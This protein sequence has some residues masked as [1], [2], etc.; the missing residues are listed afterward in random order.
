MNT[1]AQGVFSFC[2]QA[3]SQTAETPADNCVIRP[4][5]SPAER[6]ILFAEFDRRADAEEQWRLES[7]RK[8]EARAVYEQAKRLK[9]NGP[10]RGHVAD[11]EEYGDLEHEARMDWDAHHEARIGGVLEEKRASD[12]HEHTLALAGYTLGRDEF[13]ASVRRRWQ[14]YQDTLDLANAL[15]S[16]G[17]EA[18]YTGK[19]GRP[20]PS[21]VCPIS[22]RAIPLPSIRRLNFFPETAASR[23]S[24]MLKEVEAYLERHEWARMATFTAGGRVPTCE[25]RATHSALTR[26][27][28]RLADEKWFKRRAELVFRA[29]EYGTPRLCG[30][31][32]NWTWHVHAHAIF[33]PFR[34]YT[35]KAWKVFLQRVGRYMGAHWDAGRPVENARELVKYPVKPADLR[36]LLA[37]GGPMEVRAFYE[38]T[39]GL[40]I[41]ETLR[42]LRE[43]RRRLRSTTRRRHKELTND[44]RW[45][46]TIR[47]NWN[48]RG[49]PIRRAEEKA[50]RK[51]AEQ[52]AEFR[53]AMQNLAGACPLPLAAGVAPMSNR[54]VARLSPAPYA[55]RVYEPA[56]L[57]WNFNGDFDAIAQHRAWRNTLGA[58]G[59]YV[60]RQIEQV[61][62]E[63][64]AGVQQSSHQSH[65]C[66]AGP[67]APPLI[68]AP[69]DPFRRHL[70]ALLA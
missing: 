26:R 3:D 70:E 67:S 28:S 65:N 18:N 10:S 62:A 69:P 44:G 53:E 24:A 8:A 30:F 33:R 17:V 7:A 51:L 35:K 46:R 4:E 61:A 13:A 55:S 54:L 21:I 32:G 29:I 60:S 12:F 9:E 25:I 66:P 64:A 42:S 63:D 47:Q 57:V 19:A 20:A 1:P 31:S 11:T 59:A 50:K 40:R 5:S 37:L 52:R 6:V 2:G 16:A 22:R 45:V 43:Q 38:Q 15:E 58:V 34:R 68:D 41:C 39:L 27:L 14:R 49:G 23:R 36:T 56:A 48:A